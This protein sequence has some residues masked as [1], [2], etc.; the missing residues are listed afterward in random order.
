LWD[1]AVINNNSSFDI[2]NDQPLTH[3]SGAVPTFNNF[4]TVLKSVGA[5]EASINAHFFNLGTAGA[6][7]G[8]IRFAKNFEQN[9]TGT[10]E[11]DISTSLTFNK[12]PVTG[13]ASLDGNLDIN[14][15]GFTPGEGEMF[16]IMSFASG[17]GTFATIDGI[18]IGNGTH[19]EIT[20]GLTSVTLEV[21]ADD[22]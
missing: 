18:D 13:S 12:Y 17:V 7:S 22:P 5:G 16:E 11:V 9:A 10:L 8:S 2:Q 3:Y 6:D 15:L 19:F 20:Y 14:L 21:M 4:G 1:G